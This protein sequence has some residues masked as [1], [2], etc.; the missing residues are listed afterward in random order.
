MAREKKNKKTVDARL[1]YAFRNVPEIQRYKQWVAASTQMGVSNN[2]AALGGQ[3]E[4]LLSE[5]AVQ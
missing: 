2:A 4:L 1:K 5:T 3:K